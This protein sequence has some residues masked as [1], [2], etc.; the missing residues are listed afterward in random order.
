MVATRLGNDGDL[1]AERAGRAPANKG[2]IDDKM[3]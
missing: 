2:L 3:M 1:K